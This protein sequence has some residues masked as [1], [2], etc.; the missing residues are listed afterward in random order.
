[1][2]MEDMVGPHAI[3]A[4]DKSKNKGRGIL[5]T[6]VPDPP[7]AGGVK[8]TPETGN[9]RPTWNVDIVAKKPTAKVSVQRSTPR[10]INP[11]P[12]RPD[13]EVG[14]HNSHYVEGLERSGTRKTRKGPAFV[15]KHKANLMK[16]TTEE[17]CYVDSGASNHMTSHEEWFLYQE[18]PE[19]PGVV[20]TGDDTPHP[21]EHIGA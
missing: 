5:S 14:I 2:G 21:I 4:T 11:D 12:T 8:A 17:V 1:M 6:A 9:Q 15:M 7:Q 13:K 18:K 20:E 3:A 16:K 10:Q 19:K